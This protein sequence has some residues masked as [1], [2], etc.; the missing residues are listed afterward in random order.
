MHYLTRP[1]WLAFWAL[2][3]ITMIAL[4]GCA[5]TQSLEQ[6][7]ATAVNACTAALKT[8]TDGMRAGKV[9]TAQNAKVVGTCDGV[10]GAV[11]AAKTARDAAT[12]QAKIQ[13]A[14]AQAKT[15]P[16]VTK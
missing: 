16:G 3:V 5:T 14:E 4:S 12:A 8:S 15:L 7:G 1:K 10:V 9:T 11:A 2:V 6:R 13:E